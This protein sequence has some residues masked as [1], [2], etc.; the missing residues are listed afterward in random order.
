M[1]DFVAGGS[2]ILQ[3]VFSFSMLMEYMLRSFIISSK[4]N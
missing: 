4:D 1:F 3:N 2:K